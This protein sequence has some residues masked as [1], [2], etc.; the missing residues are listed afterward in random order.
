MPGPGLK[1][2]G[3]CK[4]VAVAKAAELAAEIRRRY[5]LEAPIAP[6]GPVIGLHVGPGTL[7]I[8]YVTQR[9]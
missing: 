4:V 9:D 7:G 2:G 3:G 5:G 6:I 8:V 1:P